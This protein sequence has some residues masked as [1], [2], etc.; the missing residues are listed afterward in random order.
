[1]NDNRP[2][3][4]SL[5][6]GISF[7]FLFAA[8][9]AA[10]NWPSWRGPRRDG[11]S[12]EKDIPSKWSKTENVAWRLPLPGPAGSTPIVWDDNIFLTTADGD[13]LVFMC[14][15]TDGK[16]RWRKLVGDGNKNVR[17]DEGNSAA[18]SPSTDG[19]QVYVMFATG[20]LVCYDFQGNVKWRTDL[21]ARYGRFK[22]GFGM[23]TSPM[24]YGRNLYVQL[25]HDGGH[26]VIA[27]G[28]HNGRENWIQERPSDARA[29]CRHAYAS[30]QIYQDP[31]RQFLLT[32]GA[33]YI[34]AHDLFTGNELWRCGNLHPAS[35]YN[36]TL[37]F[38]SSPLAVP[39]MIVVPSAKKGPTVALKPDG[40]GDI[41]DKPAHHIWRH[42]VT[43][44][45][46]SPL[47]VDSLVYLCRENGNLVCLD[48]ATGEKYYEERTNPTRHRASP[49]YADGKIFLIAR[50]GK[51]TVVKPGKKFEVIAQ[52]DIEEP[53]ASSPAIS[54][55]R[56]YLRSFE[57]LYAIGK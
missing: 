3:R 12:Q 54:N 23:A 41:T 13:N 30:P 7:L 6:I 47:L 10:E 57:A 52:N 31:E 38:V 20:D 34:V 22:I 26:K 45:V 46:P 51:V 27:F 50:D 9:A 15:G 2:N 1:M 28:T 24:L 36:P 16:E 8:S 32:H 19:S 43:P 56:I 44:D 4:S 48:A 40:K 33:D 53:L 21:Q 29:E 17:G 39:G 35:G 25:I 14:I 11:T 18:P 55:G 5:L 42:G 37:R 49:V